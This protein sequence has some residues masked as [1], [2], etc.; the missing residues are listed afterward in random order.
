[1]IHRALVPGLL[2]LAVLA[3]A[4]PQDKPKSIKDA[5]TAFH[6]GK[7][8]AVA[9]AAEGKGSEEDH[10]KL[11]EMYEFLATQKPPQGDEASWKA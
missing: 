1:M 3:G 5:M 6:T 11:L 7:D 9:K 2:S 8:S 4:G 10:K